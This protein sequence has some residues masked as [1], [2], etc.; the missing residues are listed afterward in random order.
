MRT[1][2][3]PLNLC[4]KFFMIVLASNTKKRNL[5]TWSCSGNLNKTAVRI[6]SGLFKMCWILPESSP[7]NRTLGTSDKDTKI[8]LRL[9]RNKNSSW[10]IGKK[11]P[12][13]TCINTKR[14]PSKTKCYV[15]ISSCKVELALW[16]LLRVKK[17]NKIETA[18][19]ENS[20]LNNLVAKV[21]KQLGTIFLTSVSC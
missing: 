1:T 18:F 10:W 5:K 12:N 16:K 4:K 15:P 19:T 6:R 11:V 14:M 7:E 17:L 21:Q 20:D 13:F 2:L 9:S 8:Y 3:F